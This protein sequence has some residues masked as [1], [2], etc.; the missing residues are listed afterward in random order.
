[1]ATQGGGVVTSAPN[2]STPDSTVTPKNVSDL[3]GWKS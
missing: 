1:M 3:Q 2:F